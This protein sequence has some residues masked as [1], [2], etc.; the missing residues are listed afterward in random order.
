MICNSICYVV[1]MSGNWWHKQVDM[2]LQ[3]K[4]SSYGAAPICCHSWDIRSLIAWACDWFTKIRLC[5]NVCDG[6]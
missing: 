1:I 2:P 4:G 5:I 3:Y 6:I